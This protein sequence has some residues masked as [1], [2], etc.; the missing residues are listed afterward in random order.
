L[1]EGDLEDFAEECFLDDFIG[2]FFLEERLVED[3]LKDFVDNSLKN[4][5]STSFIIGS[6]PAKKYKLI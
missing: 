1:C 6:N 5:T 4:S 3:F 2:V